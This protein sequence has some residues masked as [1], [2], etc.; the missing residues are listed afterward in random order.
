MHH[1]QYKLLLK[2]GYFSSRNVIFIYYFNWCY[3]TRKKREE[4]G[5]VIPFCQNLDNHNAFWILVP[6]SQ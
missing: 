6:L 5:Y 1:W 4:N 3:M 2:R